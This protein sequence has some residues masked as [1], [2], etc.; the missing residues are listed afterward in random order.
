[1]IGNMS[2][3]NIAAAASPQFYPQP[4]KTVHQ[5]YVS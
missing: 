4:D 5:K 2:I 3:K 1:M